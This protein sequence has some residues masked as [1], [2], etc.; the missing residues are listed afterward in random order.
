MP[1]ATRHFRPTKASR[2]FATFIAPAIAIIVGLVLTAIGISLMRKAEDAAAQ[3]VFENR[4]QRITRDME[5]RIHSFLILAKGAAG[6]IDT[7]F[8]FDLDNWN[9]YVTRIDPQRDWP[10]FRGMAVAL[11]VA[12]EDEAAFI[13]SQRKSGQKDFRI[14]GRTGAAPNTGPRFPITYMAP[15]TPRNEAVIGFDFATEPRRAHAF[16]TARD[17]GEPI[18]TA[19]VKLLN[20][21]GLQENGLVLMAPI[22]RHGTPPFLPERRQNFVGVIVVGLGINNILNDILKVPD[23]TGVSLRITDLEEELP[24]FGM[25]GQVPLS[26][27]RFSKAVTLEIGSRN[28]LMLFD[29]TPNFDAGVDRRQSE[30][31]ALVGLF[32]TMLLAAA[33][34]YQRNLRI[35]AEIRAKEMTGNLR[36]S[37]GRFR[38][39]AEAAGEGIWEQDFRNNHEFLSPRLLN[40]ILGYPASGPRILGTFEQ[41]VHPEDRE[42]WQ[43]ARRRHLETQAPYEVEYRVKHADGH[44]IWVRSRGQALFDDFGKA[45]QM[46]GSMADITARKAVEE[47]LRQHRDNLAAMVEERTNELQLAKEAAEAANQAKS[48]FLANMS[49]ELRTPLH[50]ILSFAQLGQ[51]R[52]LSV[53]PEKLMG[54]FNKIHVSGERLVALVNDLLDLSKLEAGKMVLTTREIDLVSLIR[55]VADELEPLATSRRQ[56]ID[57][58]AEETSAIATVDSGRFVQVMHNLFSNAIKFSPPHSRIVVEVNAFTMPRG[59]RASDESVFVPA[60]RIAVLDEGVGIPEEELETVFD[61]FV[62]SSKTRTGAGGTGLGLSICKEIVEAHRGSIRA[63]NRSPKEGTPQQGTVFEILIP[64]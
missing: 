46:A 24:V 22:Y 60:W 50:A 42:R 19:P 27:S 45:I 25:G 28:W 37:E 1:S 5:S 17:R 56:W 49:H 29:S 62:Q 2:G 8:Q 36:K 14:W 20:D 64:R 44:W 30:L 51:T 10:G 31:V 26:T 35:R 41:M 15:R 61:K 21:E 55:D 57:L 3:A 54:Y 11:Q 63:Y 16:T 40:G 52:S 6:L 38:L 7:R 47:E 34:S 32:A 18:L 58:P 12:A 39:V 59:R 4:A 13:A 43:E 23:V 33:I 48:E 53:A 9:A